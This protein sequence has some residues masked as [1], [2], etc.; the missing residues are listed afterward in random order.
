MSMFISDVNEWANFT[1]G[2]S[3]LGDPRRTER[4]IQLS[5]KMAS[6]IGQ[7]IVKSCGNSA[8]TEGAYRLIRNNNVSP[9]AISDGGYK[10]TSELAQ[11]CNL[12][13]ALEDTTD[14]A[15]THKLA[16]ELGHIG[17]SI[18]AKTKGMLIH[19]ILMVDADSNKTLGL[20]DQNRWVRDADTFGCR[21]TRANRAFEEKESAK[22]VKASDNMSERLGD[23]LKRTI[24][25]CDREADI[26][27][28]L[29]YK[30]DNNQRYLVRATFNRPLENG[31]RLYDYAEGI[32]PCGSYELV[33][34][35]R[36][37]RK[38]HTAIMDLSYACVDVLAPVRKQKTL[39]SIKSNVVICQERGN[40]KGL[41][42]VLLTSEPINSAED[43][44]KI[45]K[46]YEMRWKIEEYHKAWKSGGTQVEKLRMQSAG[47][48]ERM[49]VILGFV[50]VRLLQLREVGRD[51]ML[52]KEKCTA[53]FNNLQWRLLWAKTE[54]KKA[55]KNFTPTVEW[56]YLSLGKL[57][58]WQNSKNN[59]VVGWEALW[60]GWQKLDVLVEGYEMKLSLDL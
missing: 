56:A 15:Y 45:V 20:I 34:A 7:S 35:Q 29:H 12:L 17:N 49:A 22:W 30:V 18:N 42:W 8:E 51:K 24:S 31:T 26:I 50:A 38:E 55:M 11:E 53:V 27:E 36:G 43:A 19:S 28:Y 57:G 47:N 23:S 2:N 33:V 6:N 59:N 1:L 9:K 10:A 3:D 58:G 39:G 32:T 25:V 21:K 54:N 13:L 44:R 60:E 48:I 52:A 37:G 16:K 14:I 5:A 41:K 46:Y 4:L 40:E